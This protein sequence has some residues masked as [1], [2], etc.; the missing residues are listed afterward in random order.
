MQ[1]D[2]PCCIQIECLAVNKVYKHKMD[3]KV[4]L[5]H[6]PRWIKLETEFW[7]SGLGLH[8]S[9]QRYVKVDLDG[10][11]C[12]KKAHWCALDKGGKHHT[13]WKEM[14]WYA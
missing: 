14:L 6:T 10:L 12:A 8:L 3:V 5:W 9:L 11:S 13:R 4:D 1:F 2:P 7:E